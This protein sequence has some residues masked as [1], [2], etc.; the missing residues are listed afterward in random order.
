VVQAML[1]HIETLSAASGT[2]WI[3]SA[4]SIAGIVAVAV[5]IVNAL[6]QRRMEERLA[7]LK[8]DLDTEVHRRR[9]E[10][11]RELDAEDVLKRY[12]EPLAAAAFDLQSRLYNILELDFMG[13][14]GGSHARA[15]DAVRTTLF[16]LAQ[17]F[18]WTEILRRHIQ[19]LS[20]PEAEETRR[21]TQLQQQITRCFLTHRPGEALMVWSDEQRAIGERMIVEEHGDV[22]CMGYAGFRDACD[23]PFAPWCARLRDELG[24]PSAQE[25]MR[26][27]QHRLCDLVRTL[28]PGELRYGAD[29]LK[30]A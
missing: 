25:R 10:I 1:S 8:S 29:Q 13:L 19:F 23:G 4:A 17:Y 15:D 12:R 3:A 20:F 26:E 2:G 28:D 11:D 24:E 16:R 18:G 6:R 27:V 30:H 9:A 5:G 14:W 21:V 22:L 7:R